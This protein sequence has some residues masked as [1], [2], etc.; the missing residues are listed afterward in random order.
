MEIKD[1]GCLAVQNKPNREFVLE[2]FARDIVSVAQLVTETVSISV[3]E[4]TSLATKS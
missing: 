1:I 4:E 2:H 3:Q